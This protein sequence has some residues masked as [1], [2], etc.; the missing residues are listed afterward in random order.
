MTDRR[1]DGQTDGQLKHANF[2]RYILSLSLFLSER[3]GRGERG[4]EKR[5]ISDASED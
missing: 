3:G 1:T 2:N 4:E 5:V